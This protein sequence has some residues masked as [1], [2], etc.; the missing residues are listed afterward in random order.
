M[1]SFFDIM[2]PWPRNHGALH[3]YVLPSGSALE[4]L[5]AAQALLEG[6]DGLPL[7]P[8]P[9]LHLTLQRMTQFDEDLTQRDLTRLGD[10]LAES[11]VGQAAFSVELGRPEVVGTG[12]TCEGETP[13]GWSSLSAAVR[14]GIVA[15]LGEEPPLPPPPHGPHVSLS[16]ATGSV[17]DD[18]V[19]ARLA[20][21]EP[22]GQLD[23]EEVH[24]VSVTVRPEIGIFDFTNFASW[25]LA[26]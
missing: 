16:Y 10:A 25:P 1:E 18:E 26:R 3:L 21:A 14:A 20:A 4:R 23:V 5:A 24:L 8:E 9:Y 7:Q 11:L 13:P 22:I 17:S 2:Q 12:V 6:I 15:A 19:T